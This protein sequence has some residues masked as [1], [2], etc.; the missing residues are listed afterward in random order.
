MY[1]WLMTVEQSKRIEQA[2]TEVFGNVPD[3]PFVP[4]ESARNSRSGGA[5]ASSGPVGKLRKK[6]TDLDCARSSVDGFFD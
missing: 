1:S 5:S 3:M 6:N 4:A 2:T